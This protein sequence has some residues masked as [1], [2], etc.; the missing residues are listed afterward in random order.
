MDWGPF[1]F[2]AETAAHMH[3]VQPND[4][5]QSAALENDKILNDVFQF[6]FS[7]SILVLAL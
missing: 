3:R 4:S 7:I 6:F 1:F 5:Q 2:V